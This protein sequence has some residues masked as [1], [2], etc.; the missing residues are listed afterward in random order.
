MADQLMDDLVRAYLGEKIKQTNIANQNGANLVYIHGKDIG[1]KLGLSDEEL[2]CITPFPGQTKVFID[3]S[4]SK[5]KVDGGGNRRRLFN[6]ALG[7][8][9]TLALGIGGGIMLS[10]AL[11]PD[12]NENP[13]VVEQPTHKPGNVGFT[14]E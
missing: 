14:V 13:P 1:R 10:N 3:E 7:G 9:L 4:P 11:R 12:Q 2:R 6:L 8:L 5:D